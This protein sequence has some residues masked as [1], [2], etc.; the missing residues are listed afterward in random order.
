MMRRDMEEKRIWGDKE[1]GK[2]EEERYEEMRGLGYEERMRGWDEEIERWT[3][4]AVRF[5]TCEQAKQ[6]NTPTGFYFCILPK[7]SG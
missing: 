2:R 3:A 1:K 6:P 5:K 4:R 7:L